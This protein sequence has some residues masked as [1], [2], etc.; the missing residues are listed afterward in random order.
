MEIHVGVNFDS[1]VAHTVS[2]TLANVVDIS[3][4]PSQLQEFDRAIFGDAA[5]YVIIHGK[6][7]ARGANVY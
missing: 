1:G 4:L 5:Y 3:K 7:A 2:I 6:Y